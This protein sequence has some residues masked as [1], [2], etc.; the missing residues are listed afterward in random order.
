MINQIIGRNKKD[1]Q[2]TVFKKGTDLV[3]SP[4][5][6][7]NEFNKFFVNIGPKL[8]KEINN[9]GKDY[10]E[11]INNPLC[12]NIFMKPIVETEII[13]II[14]KFNKNKSPGYDDIGNNDLKKISKEIAIPLTRIFNLSISSGEVP[15]SLKIAKVV[16]IYKKSDPQVFSNYRPVSVLPSFS[17]IIERLVFNRCVDFIDKHKILNTNQYGFR[18]GPSTYMAIVDFVDN[19][20]NAVENNQQ[21]IGIFL[22]LSKAFD[23]IDHNILL[24]KLT[25]YGFRG[26]ALDWFSSYLSNRKQYVIYNNEKST[27]EKLTCGVPQGS[28]LGSLLFILYV[29]DIVNTSSVLEFV[30]FADDTTILYSHEDL[31]SKIDVVNNELK[32]VTNWFKANRLSVNAKKTNYMLLETR[33]RNLKQDDN[34]FIE[35]DNTRLERVFITKF[36]GVIIDENLTWKNHIDGV[37]KTISQNIGV[38]NKLK[39]FVPERVLHTLYCTLVLPYVNYNILVW[40]STCCSSMDKILKLQKWAV[41]SITKSHYRSHSAPLF[42][43]LKILNVYDTYKLEVGVFMFRYSLNQL[44]ERVTAFFS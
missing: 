8:A 20:C 37:T 14:S 39:Y 33:Q 1:N 3:T 40:G 23:T 9:S 10:F 28:I 4:I 7:A 32:E 30:L 19:I 44:P 29:N 2:Q 41:R 34:I 5:E 18:T 25:Y 22:D 38:I 26:K 17:K 6:I 13:K 36:L 42:K 27:M 12:E 21:S 35:L 15:D 43:Q 16:P 31:A 11:Y 24:H